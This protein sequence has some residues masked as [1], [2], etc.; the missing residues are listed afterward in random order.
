[1]HDYMWAKIHLE[2]ANQFA[3]LA[4]SSP[5]KQTTYT[6]L[7]NLTTPGLHPSPT[8]A[9]F[10]RPTRKPD[11]PR[12]F[13]QALKFKYASEDD[14]S[15]PNFTD[16]DV[17]IVFATQPGDNKKSKDPVHRL[18]Q[19]IRFSGK[20]AEE[21]GFDKIRK[22]LAK[23]EELRIVIL[24]GLGMWRPEVRGQGWIEGKGANDVKEACP[25]AV[26]LDLSRNLFEEWREVA[27]VCEQLERLRNLRVEYV[28]EHDAGVL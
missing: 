5:N 25:R 15:D 19:P 7:I 18:N 28:H 21:V 14:P 6:H 24:D 9:S 22:Q 26:E 10:V 12:S 3:L 23:L 17:Q 27:S 8:S 16:P 1:M 4:T 11:A 2:K 13:T 20:V